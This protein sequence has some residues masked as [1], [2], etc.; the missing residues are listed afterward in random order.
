MPKGKKRGFMLYTISNG[1]YTAEISDF[2]A[3]LVSLKTSDGFEIMWEG[4]E[5]WTKHAP[6]LFPVCGRLK[7][8]KYSLGGKEYSIP[9]HGFIGKVEFELLS[10][11]DDKISFIKKADEET[12]KVYPFDFAFVA[13]YS[14]T[15]DALKFEVKIKNN[16]GEIMPYM[17]GW[18]PGFKYPDEVEMLEDITLDFGEVRELDYHPLMNAVF[19]N[20][21]SEKLSLPAGEYKIDTDFL[22]ATD[23]I[24]LSGTEGSVKLLT[25]DKKKSLTLSY[26][27][28]LPYLCIWKAPDNRARYICLEPWSD[29]PGDGNDEENFDTRKMSRLAPGK[30]ECYEYTVKF[31]N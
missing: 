25:D 4:K 3:E 29:I 27:P 21:E 18:H 1:K 31:E 10:K 30:C 2:G 19:V 24:I 23:T 9:S 11:A 8:S 16:S 14:L 22:Y 17:F 15:K 26:S 28:N 7:D 5:Y 20:P 12:L 6:L 13:E